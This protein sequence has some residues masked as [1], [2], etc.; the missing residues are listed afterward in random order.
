ME[1]SYYGIISHGGSRSA[2]KDAF[3]YRVLVK[4]CFSLQLHF[5]DLNALSSHILYCNSDK[6]QH[7]SSLLLST[8]K[9]F[10]VRVIPALL[11]YL[12]RLMG[13]L[14]RLL[15]LV[16][17]C[18]AVNLHPR[19]LRAGKIQHC[20]KSASSLAA[21]MFGTTTKLR[22]LNPKRIFFPFLLFYYM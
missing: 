2:I 12:F 22:P 11:T 3:K 14:R 4:S 10:I 6:L 21:Q 1:K 15:P 19:C 20:P 8:A 7:F 9:D 18:L 5:H 16:Q 17:A 13:T